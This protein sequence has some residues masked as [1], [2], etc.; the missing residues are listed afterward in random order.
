MNV[1]FWRKRNGGSNRTEGDGVA[2]GAFGSSLLSHRAFLKTVVAAVGGAVVAPLAL[3]KSAGATYI[4]GSPSDT[5]DTNL[6]VQGN[7]IVG[8]TGGSSM[9]VGTSTMQGKL[10]VAGDV[11]VNGRQAIGTDGVVKESYYAQ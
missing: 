10:H 4:P 7:L 1:R 11:W 8:P 9:A 3:P 6:T 5:V 2:E